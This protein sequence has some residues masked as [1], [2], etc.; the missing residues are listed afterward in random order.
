[1]EAEAN[2]QADAQ[3]KAEQARRAAVVNVGT[4]QPASH[5]KPKTMDDTLNEIA[6]RRYG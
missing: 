1:V 6:R 2:R 4:G 3:G 5:V